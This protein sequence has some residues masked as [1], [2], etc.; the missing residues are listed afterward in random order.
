M[1]RSARSLQSPEKARRG[2]LRHRRVISTRFTWSGRSRTS[3]GWVWPDFGGSER[4][5]T[6]VC[7]HNVRVCVRARASANTVAR[8]TSPSRPHGPSVCRPCQH[9][10]EGRRCSG[11]RVDLLR[12]VLKLRSPEPG[13]KD[14]R[15]PSPQRSSPSLWGPLFHPVSALFSC[16]LTPPRA[17][18]LSQ[19][20]IEHKGEQF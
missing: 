5:C 17:P 3:T 18:E 13:W 6:C 4:Q 11:T 14:S 1:D 16:P 20:V 10:T 15:P 7:V 19:N 8:D 9:V 12:D 2:H